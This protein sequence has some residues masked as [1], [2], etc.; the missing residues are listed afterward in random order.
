[1]NSPYAF[2]L[3]HNRGVFS[4]AF[5]PDGRYAVSGGG[6]GAARVWETTTGNEV[7]R[8]TH[9][10][11]VLSVVFSP[12]GQ[13][14]ASGSYDGTVRVW[15]RQSENLVT[16]H[17]LPCRATSPLPNRRIKFVMHS[18]IRLYVRICQLSLS[19]LHHLN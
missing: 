15:V 19:H 1:M 10:D 3:R 7:A 13:Y 9:D 12:D 6:D 11:F 14:V 2:E 5:S 4:V 17:V 16:K 18:L 8:M